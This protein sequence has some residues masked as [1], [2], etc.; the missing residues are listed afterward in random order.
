MRACPAGGW[1]DSIT[2]ATRNG[3]PLRRARGPGQCREYV[4]KG[5]R[6]REE[7][8][9]RGFPAGAG[10][11]SAR[12]GRVRNRCR[13]GRPRNRV[14]GD[15]AEGTRAET[16]GHACPRGGLRGGAGFAGGAG[17]KRKGPSRIFLKGREPQAA[18]TDMPWRRE[19]APRRS[20][21]R[22][23]ARAVARKNEEAP[24]RLGRGPRESS[25]DLLS[26]IRGPGTIGDVGLDFRVRDGNG[27]DPHSITAETN[28]A[29]NLDSLS[30]RQ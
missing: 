9:A 14:R 10:N 30:N 29:W 16:C 26:R 5:I 25:G 8:C 13:A 24:C 27:Y 3:T 1:S 21:G 22:T 23:P 20:P 17:K 7:E 18:C 11:D 28:S 4:R 15:S 6:I 2:E 19:R 12:R